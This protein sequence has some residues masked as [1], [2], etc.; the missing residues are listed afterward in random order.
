MTP[1]ENVEL[2]VEEKSRKG[3]I[4]RVVVVKNDTCLTIL[5]KQRIYPKLFNSITCVKEEK[6]CIRCTSQ[7]SGQGCVQEYLH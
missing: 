6:K 4:N 7:M 5:Q 1:S 2:L 3:A